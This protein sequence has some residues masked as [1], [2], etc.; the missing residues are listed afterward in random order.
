MFYAFWKDWLLLN[1]WEYGYAIL[2]LKSRTSLS[3][4]SASWLS[5]RLAS[6]SHSLLYNTAVR[7]QRIMSIQRKQVSNWSCCS[8]INRSL[9]FVN[10][11]FSE[12]LLDSLDSIPLWENGVRM[13]DSRS[14]YILSCMLIFKG[15]QNRCYLAMLMLS[16]DFKKTHKII[17]YTYYLNDLK[18]GTW[19]PSWKLQ[20]PCG[21]KC[22]S[23][24]KNILDELI[25]Q[26]AWA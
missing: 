6:G 9:I 12:V 17:Y 25:L 21:R 26:S 5:I 23:K 15:K 18:F 2:R 7:K 11:S 4:E 19:S 3:E 13:N 10:S 16:W 8:C 24:W 20:C 22:L 14:V 1:P